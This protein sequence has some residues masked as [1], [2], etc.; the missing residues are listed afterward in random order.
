MIFPNPALDCLLEMALEEDIGSGD[1]TTEAIIGEDITSQAVLL[2]KEAGVLAGLPVARRVFELL[3][4]ISW[5]SFYEDGDEVLE[6]SQVARIH[7]PS[8][9]ILQGER[10]A[11]NFLQRLSGIASMTRLMVKKVEPYGVRVVDT[12]KTTP[13]LRRLEKYAVIKGGGANHR[14]GLYD[15]VLIK[16]NHIL[17]AGSIRRALSLVQKRVGHMVKIEVEAKNLE[18][19]QEALA[20]GAHII[21][22]DNMSTSDLWEAVKLINGRALTEASG[23]I[24]ADNIE[25]VARAGVDYI[26]MGCLTHSVKAL[27]ISL[28][29]C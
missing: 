17:A 5:E 11:L 21:L 16:D 10:L 24:T 3:G 27:D 29:F 20:G 22:L 14:F 6:E 4:G 8:R 19:V 12:R 18:E 26:S 7:G 1:I 15:A 25:A 13:L 23:N 2:V 28:N 9:I